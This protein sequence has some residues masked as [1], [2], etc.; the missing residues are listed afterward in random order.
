M[1]SLALAPETGRA[2]ID[3]VLVHDVDFWTIKDRAILDQR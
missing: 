2:R 1:R 3:I